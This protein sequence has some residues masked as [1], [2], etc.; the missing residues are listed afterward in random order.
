MHLEIIQ[1]TVE[2][3]VENAKEYSEFKETLENL[4]NIRRFCLY[5][6]RAG[7]KANEAEQLSADLAELPEL[8]YL[9]FNVDELENG[10]HNCGTHLGTI[11]DNNKIYYLGLSGDIENLDAFFTPIMEALKSNTS[12]QVLEIYAQNFGPE[13]YQKLA[14]IINL[15]KDNLRGILLNGVH[16][17]ISDEQIKLITDALSNNKG[18]EIIVDDT[19]IEIFPQIKKLD[20]EIYK[21]F[22][23]G[24]DEKIDAQL[25]AYHALV[26]KE[27]GN[28][29]CEHTDEAHKPHPKP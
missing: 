12:L 28:I 16:I 13:I 22:E 18:L 2:L 7:L 8:E 1:E 21:I 25:F 24:L 6:G 4:Q 3:R 19:L 23:Q 27:D 14:D 15:K 11:L 9:D 26:A 10:T 29:V 17:N 20:A 5:S